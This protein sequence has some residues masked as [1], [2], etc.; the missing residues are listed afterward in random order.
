MPFYYCRITGPEL[1]TTH[2]IVLN[3]Q[4]KVVNHTVSPHAVGGLVLGVPVELRHSEH[5][6]GEDG[7]EPDS[8]DEGVE[9]VEEV[10][11]DA[12]HHRQAHDALHV[13]LE[14]APL[15]KVPHFKVCNGQGWSI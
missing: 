13:R 14:V 7:G 11:E 9:L 3:V 15:P 1:V 10:H 5:G 4:K 8:L 12:A 2:N 6:L